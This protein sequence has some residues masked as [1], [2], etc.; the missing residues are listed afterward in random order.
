MNLNLR[1]LA[2]RGAPIELNGRLPLEEDVTGRNDVRV[3]GPLEAR[4]TARSDSGT[5]I[6]NGTLSADLELVCSKCLRAVSEKTEVPVT[7]LFTL[8]RGIAER[9]EDVH[10]VHEEIVDLTPYLR[11]AF[12]VQLPMAAVCGES[13][14]GLCPVCGKDRNVESCDCVQEKIDPRLAGLK[15]F[16]KS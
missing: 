11:D 16:F 14:K 10:L 6:V 4:L 8:Q 15:D 12:V 7:E 9:D 5:A 1:E 2:L 3:A 13:C